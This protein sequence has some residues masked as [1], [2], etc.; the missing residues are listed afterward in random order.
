MIQKINII[1]KEIARYQSV[2]DDDI[3]LERIGK[4]AAGLK[5][6]RVCHLSTTPYGGGISEILFSTLPIELN[7]GIKIDW[8]TLHPDEKYFSIGK[9]IHN[10]LQ[11]AGFSLSARDRSYYLDFNKRLATYFH[12]G[13]YDCVIVHSNHFLPLPEMTHSSEIP[14]IWRCHLDT[15]EAQSAVW[16]FLMPFIQ[17]FK[18]VVFTAP[19][20]IPDS[21]DTP[22]VKTIMPAIDPLS[23]K[24]R[25]LPLDKCKEYVSEL[26]VNPDA[27][28][29]LHTSRLD[30]WK[31]PFAL[32]KCYYMVKDY[33]PD[34]Q[35]VITSSVALDDPETFTMLRTID[36]E[37]AKD[38]DM[39]VYTNMD[40]I[41]DLE[42]NA[43]Q[44]S[45][46][47]GLMTSTHEG[48]GLPVAETMWKT[49]PVLAT[50]TIGTALQLKDRLE[51]CLF[52]SLDQGAEKIRALLEN[53]Q[54][55]E[56]LA[57]IG[58]GYVKS[59][60]LSPRLIKDELELTIEVLNS[61]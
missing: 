30:H 52:N 35:L 9:S 6:L 20:Y 7:L 57:E 8:Y 46:H 54:L 47:I 1:E 10:S 42:V 29:L 17:H 21:L 40:G 41:G 44:R 49:R 2:V 23:P 31:N 5:G 11:G 34:L 12:P 3:L 53:R 32:I 24:N 25:E 59:H 22:V 56:E 18:G 60:F 27:P 14:W 39:H 38:E 61:R 33:I 28:I 37:A 43:L 50:N 13:N 45:T 58:H 51:Y 48:F 19:E 16:E 15:S 36:S 55:S 4:L 26:G